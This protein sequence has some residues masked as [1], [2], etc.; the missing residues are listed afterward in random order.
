M[1][2]FFKKFADSNIPPH[3]FTVGF[4]KALG[5]CF[6]I[7]FPCFLICSSLTV[8]HERLEFLH[9]SCVSTD[10][11]TNEVANN[12]PIFGRNKTDS[13]L[14]SR[15]GGSQF[16]FLQNAVLMPF[17]LGGEGVVETLSKPMAQNGC[18]SKQKDS[19]KPSLWLGKFKNPFTHNP[20]EYPLFWILFSMFWGGLF[21]ALVDIYR[22][23]K[24]HI[25][26]TQRFK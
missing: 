21:P 5:C 2:F 1:N 14:G 13:G 7:F 12:M 25:D 15:E 9:G 20:W 11:F 26:Y 16:V 24:T 4:W 17:S 18:Y 23:I 22:A 8:G 19:V 6:V 10:I 3:C